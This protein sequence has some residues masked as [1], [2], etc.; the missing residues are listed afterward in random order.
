MTH[1]INQIPLTDID[2]TALPRDRI[3]LDPSALSELQTSIAAIG[4]THPVEVWRKHA[5]DAVPPMA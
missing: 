2:A 3:A 1:T 5:P 4:L